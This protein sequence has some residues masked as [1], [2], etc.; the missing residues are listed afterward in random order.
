MK[1]DLGWVP[2]L[3]QGDFRLDDLLAGEAEAASSAFQLTLRDDALRRRIRT[4]CRLPRLWSSCVSRH[5][6]V[7]SR[8]ARTCKS[9][10]T[11]VAV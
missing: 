11:L 8:K 1:G 10:Q 2:N 6:T 5:K 4:S 9:R 3:G 7:G